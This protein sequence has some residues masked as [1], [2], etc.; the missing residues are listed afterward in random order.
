MNGNY[1]RQK[2]FL[3]LGSNMRQETEMPLM[4]EVKS[5]PEE[6]SKM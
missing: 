4:E 1:H 2:F 5:A 6:K 3:V